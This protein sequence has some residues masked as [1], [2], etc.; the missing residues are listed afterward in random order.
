MSRVIWTQQ[1]HHI[2]GYLD[3]ETAA[4]LVLVEDSPK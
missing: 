2:L 3:R 1:Q 4:A